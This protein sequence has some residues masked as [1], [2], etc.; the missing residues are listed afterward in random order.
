MKH[1]VNIHENVGIIFICAAFCLE[2]RLESQLVTTFSDRMLVILVIFFSQARHVT[3]H[4]TATFLPFIAQ[5][6]QVFSTDVSTLKLTV[7]IAS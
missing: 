7:N 5:K 2:V 4:A 6:P 3:G 1:F